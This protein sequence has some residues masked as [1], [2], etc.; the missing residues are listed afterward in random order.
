MDKKR[1]R[2]TKSQRMQLKLLITILGFLL[3]ILLLL[4]KLFSLLLHREPEKKEES[5]PHIPVIEL[6]TNAWIMENENSG[7]LLFVDGEEKRY[8]F[9]EGAYSYTAPANCREQLADIELTDGAVTHVETKTDKINGKILSAG[10]DYIE[11][12]GRGRLSLAGDYKGYRIYN[13]LEMCTVSDIAF[14]YSFTD[15]VLED[16]EVC[17][18]L[19]VKEEA[20]EDIRVLIKSGD[21]GGLLHQELVITSD[22]DYQVEY[23]TP[24]NRQ[25]EEHCAGEEIVIGADS[26]YFGEGQGASGN[27]VTI[28]PK[29]LTGRIILKNVHRSQGEPGYRGHLE[30]MPSEG[31]IA[32]VNELPMENYLYSV[33]PSEMPASYPREALKAQ[34]V[35]ARTYA[36]GRMLHAGYPVYGAHVDD[37]TSYQVYNN[38]TEQE[39][40][41]TAV[42]ETYGQ[43]LYTASGELAQTYY[44]STSCGVGSTAR[45][46]KTESAKEMDYLQSKS[47]S[48]SALASQ[49][50][51]RG[52]EVQEDLGEKLREEEEFARFITGKSADDFEVSEGWY[53]W[54]YQVKKLLPEHLCEA[55]KKRYDANPK[56][57]LTLEEGEYVGREIEDFTKVK[58]LYVEKRGAGGVAD[59]LIIAT[60]KGVYKVISEYNIRYVLNDG[61]SQVLRQDGSKLDSPSLLPSGFFVLNVSRKKEDVVGYSISGGGYG[62]G[63]GMSQ[64]GARAMA[65]SG[66]TAE[67]ILAFF[68]TDCRIK[69]IYNGAE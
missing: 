36:Y 50:A 7:L 27:R 23:G 53:R 59:E 30:L 21:Y 64:N 38:I 34:A 54:S 58:E 32:V 60:D 61:E 35:C 25:T 8:P 68:Y 48:Q 39:A 1:E 44:Y 55:L 22:G 13:T 33:V 65:Q 9:G 62:H 41:T 12:E 47:I 14:G 57:V 18:I 19:L 42:K 6:I 28:A 45:V 5:K 20:M 3:I 15:L 43:L 37:S 66:Y 63:V 52:Q 17:G 26:E 31:G 40:A 67:Q 2:L 11:L 49:A 69:K 10:S 29:A 46:W 4:G 16:G 51:A 56:L 24:D